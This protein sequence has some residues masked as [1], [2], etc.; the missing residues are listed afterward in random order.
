MAA[1]RETTCFIASFIK[2]RVKRVFGERPESKPAIFLFAEGDVE[3][4]RSK[5]HCGSQR[6]SRPNR[7]ISAVE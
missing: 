1:D 2:E 7:I 4:C 6:H 3:A 5:A